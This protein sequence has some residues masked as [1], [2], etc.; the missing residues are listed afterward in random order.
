MFEDYGEYEWPEWL[1]KIC[2]EFGSDMSYFEIKTPTSTKS[3]ET[4]S[5]TENEVKAGF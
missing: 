2:K 3:S 4:K 5:N 1:Q